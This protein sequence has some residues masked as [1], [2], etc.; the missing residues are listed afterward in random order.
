[1]GEGQ[2]RFYGMPIFQPCN[3]RMVA[4]YVQSAIRKA[5]S[6]AGV[7][8]LT[9]AQEEALALVDALTADSSIHLGMEFQPGDVQVL[10]N[11][12][13]FHSRTSYIDW[14]EPDRRRHLLRLWLAC[15][16]GP[17]LPANFTE[18]MQG[19]TRKGRPDGIRVPAVPLSAPLEPC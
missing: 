16:D 4:T 11:H 14:A 18:V 19:A 10:C 2:Q 9:S 3:G 13:T 12:W 7:P 1:M 8:K 15:E 6:I 17:M 5:Q